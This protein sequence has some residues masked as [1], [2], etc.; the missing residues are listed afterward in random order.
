[1]CTKTI[2]KKSRT[3]KNAVKLGYKTA[4]CFVLLMCLMSC[5]E[6]WMEVFIAY[7]IHPR[8]MGVSSR[9]ESKD[10]TGEK[11][12]ILQH[13]DIFS[14]SQHLHPKSHTGNTADPHKHTNVGKNMC[15]FSNMHVDMHMCE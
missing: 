14:L 12:T 4:H 8:L 3:N 11:K 13:I 5:T 9:W 1:M 2:E 6:T 10:N 7:L 15:T